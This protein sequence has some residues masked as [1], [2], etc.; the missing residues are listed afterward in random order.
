MK[1]LFSFTILAFIICIITTSFKA[2]KPSGIVDDV[3]TYT[4]EF[5]AS[6]GLKALTP[7][8]ALNR[9]AQKHSEDM[10]S[11]KVRFG[12][13]GFSKRNAAAQKQL[14]IQ[15]FAENVAYG[16][17]TGEAVVNLWKNSGGHRANMLG[18][19][20]QIGIGVAKDKQGRIFYTQVFSD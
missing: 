13:D 16:V 17:P 12:H 10:A 6:K 18:K 1:R 3:L 7:N 4:N 5:R 11:G 19:Y 2:G 8:E 9:I 14:S 15:Y 20:A